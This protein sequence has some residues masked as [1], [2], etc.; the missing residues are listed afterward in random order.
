V[1]AC[2]CYCYH[3]SLWYSTLFSLYMYIVL[4]MYYLGNIIRYACLYLLVLICEG[5]DV[6]A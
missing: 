5:I 3:Y 2:L 6:G 4:D 1:C